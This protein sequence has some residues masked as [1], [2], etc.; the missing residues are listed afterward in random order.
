MFSNQLK[1]QEIYCGENHCLASVEYM[2]NR[3]VMGWG[4]NK[5]YQISNEFP[6][7][8]ITPRTIDSVY[9]YNFN[10]MC[11]GNNF[12]VGLIKSEEFLVLREL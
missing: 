6:P 2:K 8:S 9:G 5:N 12:S 3:M 1:V 11:C 4:L 10:Q 7:D